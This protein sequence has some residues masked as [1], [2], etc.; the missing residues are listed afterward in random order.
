[1]QWGQCLIKPLLAMTAGGVAALGLQRLTESALPLLATVAVSALT[2]LLLYT[3][4][5]F[6][7]GCVNDE[8]FQW[9]RRR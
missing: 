2:G 6:L 8:D 7:F 9:L 5:L 4:L 3:V 1:M